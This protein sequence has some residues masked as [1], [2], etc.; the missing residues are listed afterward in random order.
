MPRGSLT[1]FLG[2]PMKGGFVYFNFILLALRDSLG[3]LSLICKVFRSNVGPDL[4]ALFSLFTCARLSDHRITLRKVEPTVL[5]LVD[6]LSKRATIWNS[7]SA[8]VLEENKQ[9]GLKQRL[10]EH[11]VRRP[12]GVELE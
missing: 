9:T 2:S 6:C 11:L 12:N 10:D 8:A 1:D 5:S 3:D 4:Q 7:L